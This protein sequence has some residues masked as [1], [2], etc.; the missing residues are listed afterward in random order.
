MS[1][2]SIQQQHEKILNYIDEKVERIPLIKIKRW[3]REKDIIDYMAKFGISA[4]STKRRLQELVSKKKIQTKL[5]GGRR[6]YAP[7]TIPLPVFVA[8][9]LTVVLLLLY[10]PITGHISLQDAL[11][12]ISPFYMAAALLFLDKRINNSGICIE[13]G[14]SLSNGDLYCDEHKK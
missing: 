2:L 1:L 7:P 14:K 6:F 8:T 9:V 10:Y 11:F 12:I 13:C 4:T 3:A 5:W